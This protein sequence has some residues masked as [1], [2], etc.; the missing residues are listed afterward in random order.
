VRRSDDPEVVRREY[1]SEI[2]LETRASIYHGAE[3]Q[4]AHEI[5]IELLAE[6]KS[7]LVLDVGCGP[8]KLAARINKKWDLR[9][10]DIS[11][12][13]VELARARGI[14][15]EVA[16]VQDLPFKDGEFDIA[17]AAWMLF[18]VPDLTRGLRDI[19]RVLRPGGELIAVTNG[20][21]HLK[22]LWA[23]VGEGSYELSFNAENGARLLGEHFAAVSSVPVRGRVTFL[24][25]EAVRRYVS[26]SIQRSNLAD[27]V[28]PLT[29]P[30]SA[31]THQAILVATTHGPPAIT[32]E[33][34]EATV[35]SISDG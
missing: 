1:S 2:G 35:T 8:G 32:R 33:A 25:Q 12:R 22:E 31:R 16:D 24:D 14:S 11:P 7:R 29:E 19:A 13:M 4:D 26:A 6:R 5:L 27:R 3:G 28:P 30:L 18:H 34:S 23:L 9:A 15:A 10:V 17:V 21:D 20:S